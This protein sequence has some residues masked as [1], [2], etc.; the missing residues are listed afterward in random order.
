MIQKYEH[1][2]PDKERQNLDHIRK[3]LCRLWENP[4]RYWEIQQK[5]RYFTDYYGVEGQLMDLI[6]L[7]LR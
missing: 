7:N 2:N 1:F 5:W 3:E 6:S 4:R